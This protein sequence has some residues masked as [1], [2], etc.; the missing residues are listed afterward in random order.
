[1]TEEEKKKIGRPLRSDKPMKVVGF[2]LSEEEIRDL[3]EF[4]KKQKKTK[5]ALLREIVLDHI[6]K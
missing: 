6:Y 4:A 5:S 1:M 3:E 2:K